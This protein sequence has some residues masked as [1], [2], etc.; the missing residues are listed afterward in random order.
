MTERRASSRPYWI[1]GEELCAYCLHG[2]A[3]A[4]QSHCVACDEPVCPQCVVVV[5]DPDREFLCPVCHSV[6]A[7]EGA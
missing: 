7:S 5:L 2:Y 1:S 6:H 4:V 3:Q